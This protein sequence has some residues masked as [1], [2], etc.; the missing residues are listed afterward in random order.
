M[1]MIRLMLQNSIYIQVSCFSK[2]VMKSA[3]LT[4]LH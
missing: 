2:N 1:L 4:I 3:N